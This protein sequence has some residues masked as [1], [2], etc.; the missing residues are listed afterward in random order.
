MMEEC[1]ANVIQVAKKC[2]DASSQFIIPHL[3]SDTNVSVIMTYWLNILQCFKI[4]HY[5]DLNVRYVF[6]AL[7][8]LP[9]PYPSYIRSVIFL[10]IY[11][12]VKVYFVS[13]SNWT[14]LSCRWQESHQPHVSYR[15]WSKTSS[16]ILAFSNLCLILHH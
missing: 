14:S 13:L 8:A 16:T 2:E 11:I 10:K 7:N 4:K 15:Q 9:K 6:F 12:P 5:I 1:C 3:I